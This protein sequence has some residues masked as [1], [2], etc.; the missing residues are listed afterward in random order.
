[1]RERKRYD[2]VGLAGDV[3]VLRDLVGLEVRDGVAGAVGP[4]SAALFYSQKQV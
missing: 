3:A 4:A 1:M 2:D